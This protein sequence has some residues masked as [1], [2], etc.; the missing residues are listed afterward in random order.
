LRFAAFWIGAGQTPA[1]ERGTLRLHYVQ[2]PI[3]HERYDLA[4]P[5]DAV[6]V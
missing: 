6:I 3:D 2:K 4:R 1:V 5:L